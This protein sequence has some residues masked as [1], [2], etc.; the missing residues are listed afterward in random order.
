MSPHAF[1]VFSGSPLLPAYRRAVLTDKGRC[2]PAPAAAVWRQRGRRAARPATGVG[3]TARPSF[4]RRRR[5][6]NPTAKW[7][8]WL[9]RCWCAGSGQER[10]GHS[11]HRG[12]AAV[13]WL[14]G[15]GH[16]H[17][18]RGC[19]R[20]RRL[21]RQVNFTSAGGGGGGEGGFASS[22]TVG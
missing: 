10:P 4:W 3:G 1:V 5:R 19:R 2:K 15:H 21:N 8:K 18:C 16:D 13:P 12:A 9:R 6:G 7:G 14:S 22:S 11:T 20:Q 17:Q